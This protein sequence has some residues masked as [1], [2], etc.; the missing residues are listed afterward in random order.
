MTLSR[1]LAI[2]LVATAAFA[3][4]PS[5][6]AAEA[7][8][9]PIPGTVAALARAAGIREPLPR[10]RVLR[11]VI[12][13]VHATTEDKTGGTLRFLTYVSTVGRYEALLLAAGEAE[14]QVSLGLAAGKGR[15]ERLE[16]FLEW[17]GLDLKERNGTYLVTLRD[18]RDAEARRALLQQ[19]GADPKA[20]ELALNAGKS[21]PARLPSDSVPLPLPR[22]GWSVVFDAASPV[23]MRQLAT[24]ILGA[25]DPALLYYGLTSLDPPTLAF[26]LENNKALARLRQDAAAFAAASDGLHVAGGKV[27]VPG[28]PTVEA[29]WESLVGEPPSKPEAFIGRLFSAD[30]GRLAFFYDTLSRLSPGPLAFAL[31]AAESDPVTRVARFQ[32]LYRACSALFPNWTPSTLPFNRVAGDGSD[33]LQRVDVRAD[34]TLVGP[35]WTRL[36]REVYGGDDLPGDPASRLKRLDEDG[37]LDAASLVELLCVPDFVIRR[38]RTAL[39][40]FAQRVFPNPDTSAAPNLLLTLRGFAR[41]P[42]LALTLERMGITDPDTYAAAEAQ[43]TRLSSTL[44]PEVTAR[45]VAAFQSALAIVERARFARTLDAVAATALVRSLVA[46]PLDEQGEY[47]GRMAR[48]FASQLL[49]ALA[50]AVG[51]SEAGP[52]SLVVAAMA[53]RTAMA[54]GFPRVVWEEVAYRVDPALTEQVRLEKIRKTQGANRLDSVLAFCDAASWLA[55]RIS[56]PE[57]LPPALA[58]LTETARSLADPRYVGIAVGTTGPDFAASVKK[59]VSSAAK[60]KKLADIWRLKSIAADVVRLGDIALADTTTA[61]AYVAALGD[62]TGTAALAP[63]LGARHDLGLQ[64][65]DLGDRLRGPWKL[66]VQSFVTGRS[67]HVTGSLLGLDVALAPFALRRVASERMPA[68]PTINENER[69]ALAE[70]VVLTNRHDLRDEHLS[71]I[72]S[73]ISRGERIVATLTPEGVD[74]LAASAPLSSWRREALRWL[75][76]HEPEERERFFALSELLRI[77]LDGDPADLLDAW[78]TTEVAWSGWL[79]LHYPGRQPWE[80]F[81]GRRGLAGLEARLP[82]LGL[83]VALGLARAKLPAQLA[84]DILAAATQDVIDE[85]QLLHFDDWIGATRFVRSLSPAK[86]DDYVAALTATGPLVPEAR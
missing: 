86:L 42:A 36:W 59:A 41:H 44:D 47:A 1:A 51:P 11:E 6:H 24:T 3:Q 65:R 56:S 82:D 32:A 10:W 22:A 84:G 83:W 20:M 13:T 71:T 62:P 60:I 49:P 15:R 2:L 26:L 23:P 12:R 67:F 55:T 78:G 16:E 28:G 38:D 14:G 21:Y 30:S 7:P 46:V 80:A 33:V 50:E 69:R 79:A 57:Q 58:R 19:A 72:A 40:L 61:L 45:S 34:G 75:L 68:P 63:D 54:R 53:G 77:G 39:F 25:R 74:S 81:E 48:W 85:V 8:A 29:L 70:R 9:L 76:T 5:L 73:A 31:G 17:A 43:A 27:L 18:G 66:P 37:R 52:E 35:P 4:V 64:L